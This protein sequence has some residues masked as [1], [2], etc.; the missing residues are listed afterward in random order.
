MFYVLAI[1]L[2]NAIKNES[3]QTVTEIYKLFI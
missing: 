3:K 2:Q 1:V